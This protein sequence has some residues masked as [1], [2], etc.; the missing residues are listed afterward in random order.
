[1]SP[2]DEPH[3]PPYWFTPNGQ[4]A[5][6]WDIFRTI[7]PDNVPPGSEVNHPAASCGAFPSGMI[8]LGAAAPKAP[9]AIPPASKL[10]GTLANLVNVPSVVLKRSSHPWAI[11][12]ALG[13]CR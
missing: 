12:V 11:H 8:V 1:M 3:F 10:G 5:G 7:L 13:L 6:C 2:S 9:L 4:L